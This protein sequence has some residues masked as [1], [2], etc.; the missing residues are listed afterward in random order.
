MENESTFERIKRIFSFGEGEAGEEE[1]EYKRRLLDSRIE[2]YLDEHF[3]EYI[4][5]YGL[6][7]KQ[8]LTAYEKRAAGIEERLSSLT[9]YT[10]DVDAAVTD[11]E[12]RV[13]EVEKAAPK[14]VTVKASKKRSK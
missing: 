11:L 7:T 14:P 5:D 2:K 9:T 12:R 1:E 10:R 13:T 8:R 4:K 3:D 6:V